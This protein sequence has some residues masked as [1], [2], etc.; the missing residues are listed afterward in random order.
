MN[1]EKPHIAILGGGPTGLEAALC[2]VD[3]GYSFTLYEASESI[4]GHVN[5][6]GHVRMFSPWVY[7]VSDRMRRHLERAGYSVPAADDPSCPTGKELVD[8][9]LDPL[10]RL[11]E[12]APHL[13]TSSKVVAVGR[14]ALLKHEEIGTA[15]RAAARF[16]LLLRN[17]AGKERVEHAGVVLDCTGTYGNPNPLGDGGVPAPGERDLDRKIC[18]WIPDF[19]KRAESWAGRTVLL[20]GAG[21]SA[22]TAAADLARF[23]ERY[24]GTRILW[25]LRRENPS[26][27]AVPDDP[28]PERARLTAEAERLFQGSSDAI[29]SIGGVVVDSLAPQNNRVEVTLRQRDGTEFSVEVDQ[30]LSLTGSVGDHSIYRQLQVHECYA[31][32][33]PMKLAAALL[34]AQTADCLTQESHGAEVLVNPEPGFFILGAKSYGRNATFLMKVGWQQVAEVFDLLEKT[35]GVGLSATAKTAGAAG[36]PPPER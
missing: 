19:Q 20:V 13:K 34:G 35:H 25:A 23:A 31:T 21:H 24:P 11:A 2:A 3:H 10:A 17:S 33:G 12:L 6:W 9:I 32:S 16:R 1:R 14:E 26:W 36:I 29:E 4:A 7:N 8:R 28:L 5:A 15:V 22:Q 18:R 27:G 30:I